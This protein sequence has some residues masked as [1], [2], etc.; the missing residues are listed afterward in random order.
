[1]EEMVQQNEFENFSAIEWVKKSRALEQRQ[2]QRQLLH[3]DIDDDELTAS[4][5]ATANGHG[6]ASKEKSA[7][8]LKGHLKGKIVDHDAG[9]FK[10][11]STAILVLKDRRILGDDQQIDDA[12]VWRN[13]HF[14]ELILCGKMQF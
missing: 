3:D 1:M 13:L 10:A 6:A 9:D 11:G 2:K 4:A 5:T 12:E 7:A 14:F 8:D